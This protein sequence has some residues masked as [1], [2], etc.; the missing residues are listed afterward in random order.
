MEEGG[1]VLIA[2]HLQIKGEVIFYDNWVT[3]S[4]LRSVTWGSC[5]L[6]LVMTIYVHRYILFN[7]LELE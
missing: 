4:L 3:P 5:F 1:L 6:P 7:L 2:V